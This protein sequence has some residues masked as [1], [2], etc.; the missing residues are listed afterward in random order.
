MT[1]SD[2]ASIAQS[3]HYDWKDSSG[4]E[5]SGWHTPPPSAKAEGAGAKDQRSEGREGGDSAGESVS[6][7]VI[8]RLESQVF[9]AMV[10]VQSPGF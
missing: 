1:R 9:L 7:Q 3:G 6:E 8:V 5:K 10:V 2:Y 4:D